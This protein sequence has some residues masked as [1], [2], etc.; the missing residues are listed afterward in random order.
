SHTHSSRTS[1]GGRETKRF[2]M[3]CL[4]SAA[5]EWLAIVHVS[6]HSHIYTR[7]RVLGAWCR[8]CRAAGAAV[9]LAKW[10]AA[11]VSWQGPTAIYWAPWML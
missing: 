10:A 2:G 4:D 6:T 9:S 7:A 5:V 1:F 8:R 3:S 11:E